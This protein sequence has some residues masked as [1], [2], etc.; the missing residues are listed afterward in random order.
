MLLR[1]CGARIANTQTNTTIVIKFLGGTT[2][3]TFA[4]EEKGR[5]K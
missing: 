5:I 2:K 1:W 3:M 4:A